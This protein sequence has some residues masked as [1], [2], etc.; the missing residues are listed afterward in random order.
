MTMSASARWAGD[1]MI[2]MRAISVGDRRAFEQLYRA[3]REGV[4]RVAW[5]IL[6]DEAGALDVV[7]ETFFALHQAAPTWRPEAKVFTW[8]TRVAVNRSL[9]LRRRLTAFFR[10]ADPAS[11]VTSESV[12]AHQQ[13]LRAVEHALRS[14]TPLQRAVVALHL[15][16][17]LRPSEIAPLVELTP[18]AARVALHRGLRRV[19]EE[20]AARGIDSTPTAAAELERAGE[21]L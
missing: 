4:Y 10:A 21:D 1:E 9:T 16:Q 7:Q 6:L 17:E 13:V 3:H 14:L 20:L 8:L 15:E 12:V 5:G 19:R 18:N 11:P 2:A